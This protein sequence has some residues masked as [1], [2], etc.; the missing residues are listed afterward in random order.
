MKK[1]AS[2]FLAVLMVL[3]FAVTASAANEA[4]R[5]GLQAVILTDDEAYFLDEVVI[6]SVK[7][8][9]NNSF[10]VKNVSVETL[11]PD[12]IVAKNGANQSARFSLKAGETKTVTLPVCAEAIPDLPACNRGDK[13]NKHDDCYDLSGDDCL[14]T[15]ACSKNDCAGDECMPTDEC[16]KNKHHNKDCDKNDCAGDD[17]MPTDECDKKK[18]SC[19]GDGT[20]DDNCY[21]KQPCTGDSFNAFL[22]VVILMFAV[23]IGV[24]VLKG[25]KKAIKMMSLVFCLLM[26]LAVVPANTLA[27]NATFTVDKLIT[28]DDTD[29]I[30][31]ARIAYTIEGAD[32][33][34]VTVVEEDVTCAPTAAPETPADEN[35]SAT[36]VLK[37]GFDALAGTFSDLESDGTLDK[38]F[39]MFSK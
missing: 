35:T 30:I 34:D 12:G 9:N 16:D 27:A 1:I 31:A 10:A 25:N 19:K 37:A 29:Y 21:C 17:C 6:V 8:K 20:C 4:S 2:L 14:P 32:L 36:S 7:V 38:L 23:A 24:L 39:D 5:D 11:L 33:E 3:S 22:W 18:G 28:I 15:D 26:I 13:D